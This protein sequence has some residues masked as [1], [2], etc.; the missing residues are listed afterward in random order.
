MNRKSNNSANLYIIDLMIFIL[1]V[2]IASL[3]IKK[4]YNI[5]SNISFDLNQNYK[6]LI[7]NF[8]EISW[9]ILIGLIAVG[10]IVVRLHPKDTAK[11]SIFSWSTF[12]S[13]LGSG[14]AIW[15]FLGFV[16]IANIFLYII[17]GVNS[18]IYSTFCVINILFYLISITYVIIIISICYGNNKK[19]KIIDLI[20]LLIALLGILRI[21]LIIIMFIIYPTLY[22]TIFSF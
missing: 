10:P 2:G 15:S 4:D 14:S 22:I 9:Y 7:L 18:V 17:F 6:R 19:L 20:G 3:L 5:I 13:F 12:W 1:S 8:I 21:I 11:R 16:A